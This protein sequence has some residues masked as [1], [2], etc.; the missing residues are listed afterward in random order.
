ML[1]GAEGREMNPLFILFGEDPV[2]VANNII[3]ISN[4]IINIEL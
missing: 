3:M 1:S 4:R 2:D